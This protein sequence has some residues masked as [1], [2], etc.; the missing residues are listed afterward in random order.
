MTPAFTRATWDSLTQ[1]AHG[2]TALAGTLR[3]LI[4]QATMDRHERDRLHGLAA[5]A[6]ALA[7]SMQDTIIELDDAEV[8]RF[9]AFHHE[10][11]ATA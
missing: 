10:E 4:G 11:Q 5:A 9:H 8:W 7:D 3:D 2:L 6:V 1:S